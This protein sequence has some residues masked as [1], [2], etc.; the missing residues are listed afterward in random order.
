MICYNECSTTSSNDFLLIIWQSVSPITI[1]SSLSFEIERSW[2][3]T[4]RNWKYNPV[5]RV[6]TVKIAVQ[7]FVTFWFQFFSGIYWKTKVSF[8]RLLLGNTDLN[9]FEIWLFRKVES[10]TIS[11]FLKNHARKT[12]YK[13]KDEWHKRQILTL[14]IKSHLLVYLRGQS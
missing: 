12:L 6:K 4:F 1:I 11:I 13:K 3:H 10:F 5:S 7:L 14:V 9:Q 8:P 2:S